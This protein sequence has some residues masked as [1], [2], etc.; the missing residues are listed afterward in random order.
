MLPLH[1]IADE[2]RRFTLEECGFDRVGFAR[3]ERLVEDGA[4][5]EEWL[6]NGRHGTMAWMAREPERR[7]DPHLLLPSARTVIVV[8]KN[9]R[10]PFDPG[11]DSRAK[12]SRYAWGRDYHNILPKRLKRLAHRLEELVPGTESRWY[13]DS[14]PMMEK[15]WAERAGLG[16]RGKH[17]T[18]ITRTHGSWVL[19]GTLLTSLE[20]PP[21]SPAT[22]LC[23]TCT[24]CID[25][26]PTDAITA[27]WQLDARRC[28]SYITIEHRPKEEAI[29]EEVAEQMEG[30][31]F[32]CDICQEVCP[33]N[34][35]EQKV[36]NPDFSPRPGVLELTPEELAV[37]DDAEVERRFTGSP[38][39][40]A[41]GP[42]LRR[43]GAAM[44]RAQ[45]AA[46]KNEP[47]NN[48]QAEAHSGPRPATA[49]QPEIPDP[50]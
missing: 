8:A 32:G 46:A 50:Q 22:E 41:G 30:W 4:R 20:L 47:P 9:Y 12:V 38:I 39:R 37:I 36:D 15:A 11:E 25:A 5:L 13:V 27:P 16:W 45:G 29:P 10:T 18:V 48:A 14:G 28:I 49:P 35:F 43:T 3:A 17:T 26:C 33:W 21:D 24:R 31:A 1:Q 7:Y 23:G 19:L 44:L 34:R 40:R 6:H 42:G 2:V